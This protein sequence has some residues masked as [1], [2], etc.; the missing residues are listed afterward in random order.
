MFRKEEKRITPDLTTP[1]AERILTVYQPPKLDIEEIQTSG[2]AE[3]SFAKVQRFVNAG[4][5]RRV[6]YLQELLEL[7][8]AV[9]EA[10]YNA[11]SVVVFAGTP[12]HYNRVRFIDGQWGT[13]PAMKRPKL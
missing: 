5:T 3:P 6:R 8:V 1:R 4:T 7:W 11:E 10:G 9:L 13:I 12:T 2:T